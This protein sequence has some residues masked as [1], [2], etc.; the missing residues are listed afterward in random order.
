MI[1]IA[2]RESTVAIQMD[3]YQ[4]TTVNKPVDSKYVDPKATF[5]EKTLRRRP[6]LKRFIFVD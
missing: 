6:G 1:E 3:D 4:G 5:Y 2:R